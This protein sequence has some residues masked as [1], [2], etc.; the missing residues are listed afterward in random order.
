MDYPLEGCTLH[1]LIEAQARRTPQ[2]VALR[3]EGQSLSYAELDRRANQLAN[4]LQAGGVGP[5]TLVGVCMERSPEM[6]VALLGI[7]KA[8][9]AY[10][11]L[12]PDYPNERLAFMLA[13]AA[14]PVLL[15]QER[16]LA[17]LP[18]HAARVWC[19]D[20]DWETVARASAGA[21][22]GGA[23]PGS[24]AY[25]IYTSGSTGQPKGAMNTHRGICNR[26]LWMQDAY[27]LG[28]EDRVL[29]KTPFSFDVSVWEFFW[30]LLTGAALVLARPRGHGDS[31]YLAG[32]IAAQ[33][34]TTCHFVPADARGVPGGTGPPAALPEPAA[35]HLQRR[36]APVGVA[37][38]VFRGVGRRGHHPAQPLRPDRGGR[39][40]DFWPCQ[41]GGP[42]RI[43]P[44]GR[45]IANTQIY[46][47][48]PCG[49]PVPVGVP[50]ELFIG[51]AGVGRGYLGRPEL[52]AESASCPIPSRPS[53]RRA[54]TAPA[55]WPAGGWTATS[56]TWAG[57]ITRSSCAASASN[58]ARSR[59]CW[60]GSPGCASAW[61][62]RARTGP[63]SAGWWPT[64]SASRRPARRCATRCAPRCRNTWCPRR[65]SGCRPC[66]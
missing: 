24:L 31:D 60:V 18:P 64:S 35:G 17:H 61:C 1:G 22:A 66:R 3:C 65:S 36:G 57:W 12:D 41:A 44:I 9:G 48:D 19:L 58:S 55:T 46:L 62:W 49:Q 40:R 59:R 47:L 13:D 32:L 8:G 21:P 23:G 11:P 29:Q 5:E 45:P 38:A 34:V 30:P 39:G 2:A 63:A 43:V 6:V 51:G 27:G 53:R 56:Y 25:V 10:V 28:A 14:V 26:L 50:G 20:R 4:H 37:G 16:L 54:C 52:T 7:L 33:G 15:T 42:E